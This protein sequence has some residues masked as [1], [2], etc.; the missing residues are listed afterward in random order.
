[1]AIHGAK[2]LAEAVGDYIASGS[3]DRSVLER[4]Y[5]QAWT[6]TFK[7]RLFYGA[8]LQ[9]ILMHPLAMNMGIGLARSHKGVLQSIIKKTHGTPVAL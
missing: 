8:G 5:T 1:M 4:N 2:L 3:K 9:R 7:R 6:N